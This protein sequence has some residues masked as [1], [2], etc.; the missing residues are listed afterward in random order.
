MFHGSTTSLRAGEF[1]PQGQLGGTDTHTHTHTHTHTCKVSER[2]KG[3]RAGG[4]KGG[5]EGGRGDVQSMDVKI[6]FILR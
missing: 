3:G 2:E 4:R 1:V 6:K 5:R